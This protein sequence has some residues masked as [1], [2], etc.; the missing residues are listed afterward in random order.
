[1]GSFLSGPKHL[2]IEDAGKPGAYTVR[3]LR[4]HGGFYNCVV[5]PSNTFADIDRKVEAVYG[6]QPRV[7]VKGEMVKP[8][9]HVFRSDTNQWTPV[10]WADQV[11]DAALFGGGSKP[12]QVKYSEAHDHRQATGGGSSW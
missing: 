5:V 2:G 1:M 3:V 7:L 8:Q 9:L 12:P 10:P 4:S 11:G 6:P